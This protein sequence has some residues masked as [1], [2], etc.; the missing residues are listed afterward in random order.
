MYRQIRSREHRYQIKKVCFPGL[1]STGILGSTSSVGLVCVLVTFH[2]YYGVER[3]ATF[4]TLSY[5]FM[6]LL[7]HSFI[8]LD[9]THLRD[10]SILESLRSS[11]LKT[12]I[13]Y[14]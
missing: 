1:C 13:K 11:I 3:L 9:L 8:N 12:L 10:V 2:Q 5:I 14:N 6:A 4:R 7:I